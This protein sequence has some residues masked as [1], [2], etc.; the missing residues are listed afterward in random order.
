M[1]KK[2]NKVTEENQQRISRKEM[3][4]SRKEKEQ[5]RSIYIGVGIVAGILAVLFIAAFAVELFVTPNRVVSEVRGEEITLKEWIDR[6]RFE[7][8]QY[9]IFL[10]DRLA[11]LNNDV[12]M[13]QQFYGQVIN[14]L[15]QPDLMGDAALASMEDDIVVL[16]AAQQRGITVTDAEI[17]EAIGEMFN[18]FG[19]AS[20]TAMPTATQTMVPTPSI[21]PIP[22]QVITDVLPTNTPFPTATVGPTNTPAPTPTAVSADAF[23]TELSTHLSRYQKYGISEAQYRDAVRVQL[24]REKLADVLATENQIATEADHASFFYI[25]INNEEEAKQLQADILEKGYL[26]VWNEVRSR[27]ADPENQPTASAAE[28]LWRVETDITPAF[29]AE[30]STAVFT[31]P[32]QEA[33]DILVN[34]IDENTTLYYLVMPTGRELRTLTEAVINQAKSQ[35]LA[36]FIDAQLTGNVVTHDIHLGRAP[37][38]PRLDPIYYAPLTPTPAATTAV[39]E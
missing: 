25:S 37:E 35:A 10:E 39:G 38:T 28:V 18:Y 36:S 24:Y 17:D 13:L 32:L 11:E 34:I 6:T 29:G 2:Q 12:G 14:N 4:L 33:S 16:Q 19:G 8:A 26:Q 1:T 30:V 21:T 31:A 9:I 22:T 5:N 23:Q 3:L 15:M 7:R 27:P 20:P